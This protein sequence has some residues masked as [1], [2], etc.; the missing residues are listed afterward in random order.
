MPSE[1]IPLFSTPVYVSN[2]GKMPEV[3]D[4]ITEMEIADEPYN[5]TGNM[6]SAR[7][8]LRELPQLQT[9]VMG[10]IEEYVYG[11]HG[12]DPKRH[13][14]EVT[15]SWINF[16]YKGDSA[17]GHDHCNAITPETGMIVIFPSDVGHSVTPCNLV[18]PKEARISL[19]FNVICRGE[20]GVHTKLLKI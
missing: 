3:T 2:D 16:M 8:A 5:N 11:V 15:N 17:H 4:V 14:V 10:H 19:S 20:Y 1:V 9:W 12:I 6:T 7:H 18:N 13:T